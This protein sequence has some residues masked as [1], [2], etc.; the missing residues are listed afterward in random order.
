MVLT[1][2]LASLGQ[3]VVGVAHEINDQLA[4]VSNN[5]A[6]FE[7]DLVALIGLYRRATEAGC[8]TGASDNPTTWTK[9]SRAK[10]FFE[11]LSASSRHLGESLMIRARGSTR[12]A[13]VVASA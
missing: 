10:G 1:E 12:S 11:Y 7:R 3:L 4:F 6:V 5:V 9:A 13:S 2:K 8:R